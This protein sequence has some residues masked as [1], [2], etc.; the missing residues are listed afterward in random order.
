MKNIDTGAGLERLASVLQGKPSNF[1]TDLIFP[2][3]EY[4]AKV[5]GVEYGKDKKTDVSL[6][7]IADHVR[8]ITFMIADGVLPSNEGRGYVLR[9]VLRRAV[10]HAR[11]IGIEDKFL[12]GAVDVV[13]DMFKEPYPYLVEKTSFIHKVIEMEETSFLRTLR[14]GCDLLYCFPPERYF[15]FPA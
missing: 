12:N 10:R 2:I 6:K 14:Q 4:A 15:R 7:V 13:I 1:E 5:A 11:L 8:S 9:R 3:I